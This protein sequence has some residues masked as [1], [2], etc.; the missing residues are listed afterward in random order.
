[1]FPHDAFET[2][3]AVAL[4]DVATLRDDMYRYPLRLALRAA[5]AG[6]PYG[7]PVLGSE[8]SL[9]ALDVAA[10]RAWHREH[11]LTGQLV[12][13]VVGD[14]DESE[15]AAIVARDFADLRMRDAAPVPA[16][17]WPTAPARDVEQREKAQ[18]ALALLFP[19]PARTDD[20]RRAAHILAGIASGL[21]G[22]FFDELRDKRSLAYTVH[23]FPTE[24]ERA[25]AFVAYIATG[26]EQ[27]ETARAGL[28]A[29]FAK[30]RDVPVTGEELARAQRYAIGTHAIQQESGGAQLSEMVD[31]W[32]HG[33]G[34]GELLRHDDEVRAVTP[35]R[36]Q[37]LAQRYFTEDRLVEGIV[38]GTGKKV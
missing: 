2:E 17:A 37:A 38:R 5:F 25:G 18:T 7:Q 32:L 11:L 23:A 16:P 9:R 15:I 1:V 19:S 30:L 28:L 27:E 26:P 31:A 3:R 24:R 8:E 36:I 21:G 20:D 6:H 10:A 13:G 33:R 35:E 12:I 22:R 29:E 34:L 4:S 14:L